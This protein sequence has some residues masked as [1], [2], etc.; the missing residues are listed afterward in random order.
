MLEPDIRAW[1]FHAWQREGHE[2][3]C[4]NLWTFF[5]DLTNNLNNLNV[6][7]AITVLTQETGAN[8]FSPFRKLI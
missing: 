1:L 6:S 8:A 2:R 7:E 5:D 3:I 4:E